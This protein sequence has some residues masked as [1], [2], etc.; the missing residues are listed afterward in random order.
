MR[1][2][3]LQRRESELPGM[4]AQDQELKARKMF[5]SSNGTKKP[6]QQVGSNLHLQE[7]GKADQSFSNAGDGS[8]WSVLPRQKAVG[9]STLLQL[10][11]V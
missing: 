6:V 2:V 7:K 9:R 10:Y 4:K 5:S 1:I 11:E 3:E 8:G